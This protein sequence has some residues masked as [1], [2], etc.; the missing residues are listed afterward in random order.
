MVDKISKIR[1]EELSIFH[2]IKDIVLKDY[3]IEEKDTPLVYN[4][5]LSSSSSFVYELGIDL[6]PAPYDIGRGFVYFDD[7]EDVNSIGHDPCALYPL[8]SGTIYG[9]EEFIEGTPEQEN[10]VKVYDEDK[11]LINDYHYLVDYV[12]CRVVTS[13]TVTPHYTDYHWN[14]VSVLDDWEVSNTVDPPI[15]VVSF[16]TGNKGGYQLGGG[17]KVVR[18]LTLYIFAS[19]SI[20]KNEITDALYD[21]FYNK[22]IPIYNFPLGTVLDYDGTWYGRKNNKNK[23]TSLFDRTTASFSIGN[24]FFEDIVAKDIENGV[25]NRAENIFLSKVNK[26]RSKIEMKVIYYT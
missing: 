12:D 21:G 11:Q 10:R 3:I 20:E 15:V 19:S 18:N 9:G 22:T 14:Y 26:F 5:K 7:T 25:V 2:Y 8:V 23:L 24:M 16:N 13:G 6:S 17:R 4:H 1:K